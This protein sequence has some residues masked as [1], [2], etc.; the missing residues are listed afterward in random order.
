VSS[1]S[2]GDAFCAIRVTRTYDVLPLFDAQVFVRP[3][4]ASA[5]LYAASV[6][7]V[8]TG[9]VDDLRVVQVTSVSPGWRATPAAA[10]DV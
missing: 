6:Q 2:G 1:Q 8:E 10:A 5:H 9:D 3:S 7:L 4:R